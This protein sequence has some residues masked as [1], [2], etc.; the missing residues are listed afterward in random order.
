MAKFV[1]IGRESYVGQRVFPRLA[2]L[3]ASSMV[4]REQAHYEFVRDYIQEYVEDVYFD[5]YATRGDYS[6]SLQV[7]ADV[8][9]RAFLEILRGAEMLIDIAEDREDFIENI[10]VY[11]VA[12]NPFEN[13][14]VVVKYDET[15]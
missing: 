14:L 15:R 5:L 6:M 12:L 8:T 9:R 11:K 4:Y 2:L 10:H 7:P 1:D 3:Y 13:T